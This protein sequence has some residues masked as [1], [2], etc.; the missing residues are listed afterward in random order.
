MLLVK[1]AK[2]PKSIYVADSLPMNISAL[3]KWCIFSNYIKNAH[4]KKL[5]KSKNE[6]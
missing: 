4:H 1:Y 6:S 2:L 5:G 3:L